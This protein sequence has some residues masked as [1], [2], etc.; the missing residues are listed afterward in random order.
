[1]AVPVSFDLDLLRSFLAIA[2][3][4]SFTRAA[5]RVGRTQAAVS[6]QMQRLEGLLG[7]TL[8]VRGKG[9]SVE[10]NSDGLQL[11]GRAQELLALNDEIVRVRRQG[12]WDNWRFELTEALVHQGFD[13]RR[14]L[15][16]E[17]SGGV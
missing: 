7:K 5:T 17:A 12:F 15:L 4:K 9:G 6:L 13:I 3:E 16:G 1:M 8:I 14:L 10:L 11:L 2:E